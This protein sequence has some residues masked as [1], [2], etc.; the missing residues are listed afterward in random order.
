MIQ[1]LTWSLKINQLEEK[2]RKKRAGRTLQSC[3]GLDQPCLNKRH[4][5]YSYTF[6]LWKPTGTVL[7]T[8]SHKVK[9]EW[10]F[11]MSS[12]RSSTTSSLSLMKQ[13]GLLKAVLAGFMISSMC[14]VKWSEMHLESLCTCFASS[15]SRQ[16]SSVRQTNHCA[17]HLGNTVCSRKLCQGKIEKSSN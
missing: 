15:V 1:R 5:V 2:W 11:K 16:P 9:S 4:V 6:W 10:P 14:R 12:S 8:I 3:P 17:H 13:K 7:L